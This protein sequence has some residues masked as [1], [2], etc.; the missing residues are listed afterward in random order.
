MT[1]SSNEAQ[2]QQLEGVSQDLE[3]R[4]LLL[5]EEALGMELD[6]SG[7]DEAYTL[8]Y[9]SEKLAKCSFIL[10]RLNRIQGE[11]AKIS[12]ELINRRGR[13]APMLRIK[14]KEF[15]ASSEYQ[16]LDRNSKG[17]WL[18]EQLQVLREEEQVWSYLTRVVSE[19]KESVGERIQTLRRSDSAIRLQ[20]KLLELTIGKT[21][22]NPNKFPTSPSVT[23]VALELTKE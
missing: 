14:E 15:K 16:E 12:L 18:E 22:S 21:G 6:I 11:L 5:H 2:S 7:D 13:T 9:I 23:D 17:H 8:K 4:L 10:E 1:K 19:V 3:Q 20:Q